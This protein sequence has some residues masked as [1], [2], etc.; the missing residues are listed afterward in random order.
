MKRTLFLILI[1]LVALT[2]VGHRPEASVV[3]GAIVSGKKAIGRG[4]LE[5]LPEGGVPFQIRRLPIR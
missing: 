3:D 4:L 5:S 2:A 1:L